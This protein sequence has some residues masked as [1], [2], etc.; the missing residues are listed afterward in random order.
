MQT[1][2]LISVESIPSDPK[3]ERMADMETLINV[4][5]L[6]RVSLQSLQYFWHHIYD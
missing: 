1:L 4:G 5:K 3:K 6:E 2:V